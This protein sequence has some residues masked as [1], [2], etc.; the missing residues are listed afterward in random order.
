VIDDGVV[1]SAQFDEHGEKS[2]R[3]RLAVRGLWVS[4]EPLWLSET[5]AQSPRS[6]RQKDGA[7]G[8]HL[9]FERDP[10][11]IHQ[12]PQWESERSIA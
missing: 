3:K 9:A 6:A 1:F 11:F 7:P 4:P 2:S 8:V 5:K 10:A 12:K